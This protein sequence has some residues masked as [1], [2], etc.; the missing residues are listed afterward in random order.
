MNDQRQLHRWKMIAFHL[1][2]LNL[3]W[4]TLQSQGFVHQSTSNLLKYLSSCLEK[5]V[6]GKREFAKLKRKSL[7]SNCSSHRKWLADRAKPRTN[8]SEKC[9]KL[10]LSSY[11]S[12]RPSRERKQ[13]VRC[14]VSRPESK[15][16]IRSRAEKAKEKLIQACSYPITNPECRGYTSSTPDQPSVC[17]LKVSGSKMSYRR[18]FL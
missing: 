8:Y 7:I 17:P 4:G 10:F 14:V 15:G 3:V 16:L 18:E 5:F 11:H 2:F 1:K 9:D 6:I 13:R 12:S